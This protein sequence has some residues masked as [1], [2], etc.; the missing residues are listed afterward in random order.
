MTR[1]R[2]TGRNITVHFLTNKGCD[3]HRRLPDSA[4]AHRGG[5]ADAAA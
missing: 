5:V 2:L 3:P 1:I 4:E